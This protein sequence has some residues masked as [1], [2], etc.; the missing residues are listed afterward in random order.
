MSWHE[1]NT[2][3]DEPTRIKKRF[4]W[5]PKRMLV[6]DTGVYETRWG[7]HNVKQ[8]LRTFVHND[9]KYQ[10]VVPL[11]GFKKMWVDLCWYEKGS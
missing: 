7:L 1:V 9:Y 8:W 3:E 5:F 4:Y 6:G 2:A 11:S 10:S